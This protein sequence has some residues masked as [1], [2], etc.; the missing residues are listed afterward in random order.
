MSRTLGW[1]A[2]FGLGVGVV[3]LT[4]AYA[5]GG[6]DMHRVFDRGLFAAR[7]CNDASPASERH[8]AWSGGDSIDVALPGTVRFRGGDGNDVVVRGP[9]DTIANVDLHDGRLT[10]DCRSTAS[11]RPVEVTLPGQAFRRV[12]LSGSAEID[13][14]NLSQHKLALNITGSGIARIQGT[15]DKL[16]VVVAGSGN[17]K[18]ADLAAR[19]LAVK[20]SGSGNV[21]AS[22]KDEAEITISGSGNVRL[23]SRPA[24][25][26]SRIAGSGRVTQASSDAA[27][28]RK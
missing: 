8:L 18:L 27:E 28:A 10:L 20:I 13:M 19:R 11:A 12:N 5:L 2:V 3:S 23:L 6:R 22:P 1:I 14:E 15:V 9:Q 4:L 25:L 21:E 16:S 24:R 26:K 7:A 17:A